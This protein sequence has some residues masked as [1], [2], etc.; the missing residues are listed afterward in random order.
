MP[1]II[2]TSVHW[3]FKVPAVIAKTA[4]EMK[5]I[6]RAPVW[7]NLCNYHPW[8]CFRPHNNSLSSSKLKWVREWLI[9]VRAHTQGKWFCIKWLDVIENNAVA[10]GHNS[11]DR[12]GSSPEATKWF[13]RQRLMDSLCHFSYNV[14]NNVDFESNICFEVKTNPVSES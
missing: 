14:L 2:P 1:I 6:N 13:Q 11:L 10:P 9:Y 4:L 5:W 8:L 3:H 7:A 12:W